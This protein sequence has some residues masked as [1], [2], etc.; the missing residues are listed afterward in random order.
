MST[1]RNEGVLDLIHAEH[2]EAAALF[3]QLSELTDPEDRRSVFHHLKETIEAHLACEDETFHAALRALDGG[4]E[5]IAPAAGADER[6]ALALDDLSAAGTEDPA[7]TDMVSELRERVE[8]HVAREET[9]IFDFA[10]EQLEQP[11]LLELERDMRATKDELQG[12]GSAA[13]Q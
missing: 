12:A 8:Q 5:L 13:P 2:R 11:R 7:W 9:E 3:A 4:E 6:I 10:R 1:A